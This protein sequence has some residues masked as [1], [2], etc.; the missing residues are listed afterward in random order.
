MKFIV[1]LWLDGI[2]NDED[3]KEMEEAC[4]E[5]IKD[6][7]DACGSSVEV[8]KAVTADCSNCRNSGRP[9]RCNDCCH[10]YGDYYSPKEKI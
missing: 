8:E 10:T 1:D 9:E 6:N 3:G 7:L 2:S 4:L 5:Y